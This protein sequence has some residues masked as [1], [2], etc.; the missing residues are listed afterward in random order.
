MKL[1]FNK[2]KAF[3]VAENTDKEQLIKKKMVE[4]A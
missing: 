3:S 1:N 4:K 2:P